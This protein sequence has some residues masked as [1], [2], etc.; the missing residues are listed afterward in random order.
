M[1][2]LLVKDGPNPAELFQ[3]WLNLPAEN[4]MDAPAFTMFW[5]DQIPVISSTDSEGNVTEISVITGRLGD[6]TPPPP[7]V[8]SWAARSEGRRRN[9]ASSTQPRASWELPPVTNPDTE[10]VVYVFDGDHLVL[11]E[12]RVDAG[13]GALVEA[14]AVDGSSRRRGR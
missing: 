3:I 7:P 13:T 11:D 1:F 9:L 14:S 2:P 6:V 10:R 4:K 5:S 8:S 12:E